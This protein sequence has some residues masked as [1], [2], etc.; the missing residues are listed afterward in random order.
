MKPQNET[1]NIRIDVSFWKIKKELPKR[2]GYYIG[3]FFDEKIESRYMERTYYSKKDNPIIGFEKTDNY[4]EF[5]ENTW[6]KS[7]NIDY[8]R[9]KIRF[10]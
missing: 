2:G 4:N 1:I 5:Y 9:K 10:T 7:E 6:V 3:K 8:M